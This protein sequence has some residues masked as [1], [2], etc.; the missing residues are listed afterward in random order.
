[1]QRRLGQP[2]LSVDLDLALRA[3]G[4][5]AQRDGLPD[6]HGI[7]FIEA[8]AQAHR[9]VARD[10]AFLFEEKERGEIEPWFGQADLVGPSSQAPAGG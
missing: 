3:R 1:M 7:D 5:E 4:V 8:A 9:A 10:F 2:C 6:E